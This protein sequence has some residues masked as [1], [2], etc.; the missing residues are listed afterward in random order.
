MN[1]NARVMENIFIWDFLQ[2]APKQ[3]PRLNFVPVVQRKGG[4]EEIIFSVNTPVSIKYCG[5][6][7]QRER[8]WTQEPHSKRQHFARERGERLLLNIIQSK[9]NVPTADFWTGINTR[10]ISIGDENN[11]CWK[12]S[13]L[14]HSCFLNVIFVCKLNNILIFVCKVRKQCKS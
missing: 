10:R 1:N 2:W 3:R 6:R 5:A 14:L 11:F 13:C 4:R 7:C 12:E 9:K 8:G